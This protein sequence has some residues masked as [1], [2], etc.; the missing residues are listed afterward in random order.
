[1]TLALQSAPA[2][3]R[4]KASDVRAAMTISADKTADEGVTS[5]T[6]L[7]N[8][9]ELV[10]ILP[11]G[12]TYSLGGL[13]VITG[14]AAAGGMAVTFT[15]PSTA[16]VWWTCGNGLAVAGGATSDN[17]VRSI[18]GSSVP[19]GTSGTG[20]PVPGR[21]TGKVFTGTAICTLQ[22]Q[23]AQSASNATATTMKVGSYIE[24][25]PR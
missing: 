8:D 22:L 16:S 7:Q 21:V 13:L 6:T 3:G 12:M 11:A 17:A 20:T 19:L 25:R 23:F 2:W 18:S 1:M 4:L 5:S 10:L 15:W 24:A 9:D 14:A